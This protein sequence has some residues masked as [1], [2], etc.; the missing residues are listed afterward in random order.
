M[1]K[2]K[3][4][5]RSI[6]GTVSTKRT[7][8]ALLLAPVTT[9]LVFFLRWIVSSGTLSPKEILT[10]LL[11]TLTYMLPY[12]YAAELALGL[13]TWLTLRRYGISSRAAFAFAGC[14]IGWAVSSILL[15]EPNPFSMNWIASGAP[16]CAIAGSL[17]ALAFRGISL[18]N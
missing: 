3:L 12:A 8:Y 14:A 4:R 16:V 11:S 5:P 7:I 9:P 10:G 17:S 6:L 2:Q 1:D 13:P 18:T 15:R